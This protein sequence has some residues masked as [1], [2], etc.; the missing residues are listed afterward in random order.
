MEHTTTSTADL[1]EIVRRYTPLMDD[2][3]PTIVET[4][5]IFVGL[6]VQELTQRG[7]QDWDS[8]VA[9]IRKKS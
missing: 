2:P 3:D 5:E 9:D 7:F 4:A 8:L 1:K 6:A